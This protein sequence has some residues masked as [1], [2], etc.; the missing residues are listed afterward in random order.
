MLA[1]T[2]RTE[3]HP[4]M[5]AP[6]PHLIE[7]RVRPHPSY[8]LVAPD[9]LT[10][11]EAAIASGLEGPRQ[12]AAVLVSEEPSG[13]PWRALDRST[14]ERVEAAAG[15]GVTLGGVA[16]RGDGE[17]DDLLPLLLDEILEVETETG[18]ESGIGLWKLWALDTPPGGHPLAE[19]SVR[20]VR[21]GHHVGLSHPGQL[22]ARLYFFH[23]RPVTGRWRRELPD[24]TAVAAFLG[25]ERLEPA[26]RPSGW[27]RSRRS[28]RNQGWISW[29]RSGGRPRA[30]FKLYV[31]PQPEELPEVF[32]SVVEL[33]PPLASSFKVGAD[34]YGL[35]RPDKLVVFAAEAS[36]LVELGRS[37]AARHGRTA[38]HGV[39]FTCPV[40]RRGLCSWGRDPGGSHR[41]Y[42]LPRQQSWRGWV[43][44][45]LARALVLARR[46]PELAASGW[47]FALDRLAVAGVDLRTWRPPEGREPW[48]T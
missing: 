13:L 20:A 41:G 19:L 14:M 16:R 30:R 18:W 24:E 9:H 37:L 38:V 10:E 3:L 39:P 8:R 40:D 25:L 34:A 45:H 21:H 5:P 22:A 47:R 44:A 26:L 29:R 15:R 48:W 4:R 33:L 1:G 7:R 35:L 43:A 17:G 46:R 23:R 31:S 6:P 36:P 32:A 12:P 28:P 2:A 11:Q 27:S 42:G